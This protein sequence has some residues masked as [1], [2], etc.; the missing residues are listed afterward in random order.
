MKYLVKLKR[1]R[2]VAVALVLLYATVVGVKVLRSSAVEKDDKAEMKRQFQDRVRNGIG[3]EMGLGKHDGTPKDIRA[4]VNTI[5]H[6]I[7]KRSGVKL[8]E[9]TK[10]RLVAMEERIQSG[11][12]R[13]LNVRDVA[14]AINATILER[15][16]SLSDQDIAHVDDALRGFNAPDMPKNFSRDRHL[17]GGI[18]SIGTPAEKTIGQLKGIRDQIGTPGGEVVASLIGNALKDSVQGRVQYLSAAV[19]EYFGNMW[20]TINDKESSAANG[21]ITPLQATLIA[22]SIVSDDYLCDSDDYLQK[23]MFAHQAIMTEIGKAPYPSPSGHLPYGVN[24]YNFS[25]PLDLVFDEHTVN[26]LLDRIEEKSAA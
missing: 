12:N 16:A 17:P 18:V 21:G 2:Y 20:D 13:R 5:A 15:L 24:G 1:A 4:T 6:F 22:Y 9:A 3:R 8:S 10:A 26:R 14:N 19:P 7:D 11:N 25:S 23:S